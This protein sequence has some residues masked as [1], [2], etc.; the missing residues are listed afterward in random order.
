KLARLADLWVKGLDVDWNR[1]YGETKPQRMELPGYPFAK[2]RYWFDRE[3][4]NTVNG[5]NSW[6][7]AEPRPA[8]LHPLLQAN[9]SDLSQCQYSSTFTGREPFFKD[10]W[11]KGKRALPALGS[12]EMA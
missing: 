1:L 6:L 2:E 7:A 8:V 4:I 10:H 9:T 3:D 5:V 12:V 11:I